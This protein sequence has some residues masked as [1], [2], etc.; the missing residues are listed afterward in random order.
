MS[1]YHLLLGPGQL[2]CFL[3]SLAFLVHWGINNTNRLDAANNRWFY[4]FYLFRLGSH[5]LLVNVNLISSKVTAITTSFFWIIFKLFT[6]TAVWLQKRGVAI[7][8]VDSQS[9]LR[10]IAQR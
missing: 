1:Q 9:N 2:K 8:N 7:K 3:P 10:Q 4:I 6:K 5:F